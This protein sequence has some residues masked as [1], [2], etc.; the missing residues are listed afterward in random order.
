MSLKIKKFSKKEI[1]IV[2]YFI[3][4]ILL[5]IEAIFINNFYNSYVYK[6]NKLTIRN[7]DSTGVLMADKNG[8]ELLMT[9]KMNENFNSNSTINYLEEKIFYNNKYNEEGIIYTFSDGSTVILPYVV[10][11]FN[12]N[13][14]LSYNYE[15]NEMQEQE[16]QLVDKLFEYYHSYINTDFF[17]V[18]TI[19]GLLILLLT[20]GMFFYPE[21]FWYLRYYFAVSGGEPTDF[22]LFINAI[23]SIIITVGIYISFYLMVFN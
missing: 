12:T 21:K 4:A 3:M 20:H 11:T 8:N 2:C 15:L 22:Y 1:F 19:L 10:V 5:I 16:K 17:I 18:F 23:S 13:G 14:K 9:Y 6:S 7:V